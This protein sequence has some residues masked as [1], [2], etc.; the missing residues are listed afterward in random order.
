[1]L[2]SLPIAFRPRLT[3]VD[4]LFLADFPRYRLGEAGEKAYERASEEWDRRSG[5]PSYGAPGGELATNGV[6]GIP[7]AVQGDP[8]EDG[9]VS[10]LSVIPSTFG[11]EFLDG[12]SVTFTIRR[13]DVVARRWS[14]IAVS[15]DS[16]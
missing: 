8:R 16:S 13:S 11:G 10:L 3:L 2:P 1:M 14:R 12:G 15:P 4:S 5:V 6:L 7:E 9:E